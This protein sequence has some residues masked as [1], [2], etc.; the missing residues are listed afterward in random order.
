MIAKIEKH[1]AIDN[2]ES[3][4]AAADAIM[5]A[6]GDLGVEIPPENVPGIQ[7]M[8]VKRAS[9][10]G[11]PVIIATQMLRSMVDSPRPTRAEAADVANAVYEGADAVM[12]SEETAVGSFPDQAVAFMARIAASAEKDFQHDKYLSL[13]PQ[14]D[15]SASVAYAACVLADHLGAAAIIA[16]TRSGATAR[17]I[18]RFRPRPKIIALSP[19]P[20]TVNQLSLVWGCIP[21]RVRETPSADE[22]VEKAVAAALGAGLV[23]T[24]DLVVITAGHPEYLEGTTNMIQ[25]KRV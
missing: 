12:L 5:V 22:K 4:M 8:L 18:A 17:N 11:K 24:G 19:E 15:V 10:I 6:R 2:I 20:A 14:K 13:F 23:K 25:V 7:K 21:L 3:I 16:T 1:E 9:G